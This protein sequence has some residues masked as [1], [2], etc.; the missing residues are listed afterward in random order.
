MKIWNGSVV[1]DQQR[2]P[3]SILISECSVLPLKQSLNL[4]ARVLLHNLDSQS[5]FTCKR[6]KNIKPQVLSCFKEPMPIH[7][8]LALKVI[9][10]V[11]RL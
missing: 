7:S 3:K 11:Q 10:T 9:V 4:Q 5:H 2:Y 1:T 8:E 6:S